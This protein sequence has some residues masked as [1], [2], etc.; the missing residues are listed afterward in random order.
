MFY[1]K[2]EVGRLKLSQDDTTILKSIITSRNDI[3]ILFVLESKILDFI[4]IKIAFEY[5]DKL[6]RNMPKEKP[7][8]LQQLLHLRVLCRVNVFRLITR[9]VYVDIAYVLGV[10]FQ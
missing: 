10:I 5:V 7:H 6:K 4:F 1:S 9:Y 2:I 8:L 3:S